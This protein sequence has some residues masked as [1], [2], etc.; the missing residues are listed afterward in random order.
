MQIDSVYTYEQICSILGEP[1]QITRFGTHLEYHY[2]YGNLDNVFLFE[3]DRQYGKFCSFD[4]N[5]PHFP[6]KIG[7][8]GEI[9]VGDSFDTFDTWGHYPG[10]ITKLDGGGGRFYSVRTQEEQT[11]PLMVILK[12][13][14]DAI[15]QLSYSQPEEW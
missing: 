1:T 4:I 3:E 7:I 10:F 5:T 14:M 13:L 9:K 15:M 8:S 12:S 6:V 11:D 2:T